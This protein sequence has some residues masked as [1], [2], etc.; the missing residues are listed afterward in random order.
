LEP[1]RGASR[2]RSARMSASSTKAAIS[3]MKPTARAGIHL[4]DSGLGT[5]LCRASNPPVPHP[6]SPVPPFDLRIRLLEAVEAQR[7]SAVGDLDVA[8]RV[9]RGALERE[10]RAG[11]VTGPGRCGSGAEG[12]EKEQQAL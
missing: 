12:D 7:V 4:W 1:G 11:E 9:G 5:R 8:R 2:R 6:S 10:G 3:R